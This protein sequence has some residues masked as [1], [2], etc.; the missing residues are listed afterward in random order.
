MKR[1]SPLS[2]TQSSNF[3]MGRALLMLDV[4]EKGLDDMD[5]R[6]LLAIIE[7]FGGGPVGI[8]NLAVAVG[9]QRDTLEEVYEP[10]LIQEGYLKRTP[11]GR[12]ATRLSYLH[13][14]IQPTGDTQLKML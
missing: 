9:E 7:K 14:G 11:R 10:Y 2:P 4:D 3:A 6:I 12:E 5:K 13:F 8:D 1:Q